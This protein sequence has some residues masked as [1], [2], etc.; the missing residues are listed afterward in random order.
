MKGQSIYAYVVLASGNE[1]SDALKKALAQVVRQ[2]IGAFAVPDTI[3]WAPA[4]PKVRQP[5]CAWW[6]P[7]SQADPTSGCRWC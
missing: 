6:V 4:L 7:S 3:H 1:P 2:Q 5:A